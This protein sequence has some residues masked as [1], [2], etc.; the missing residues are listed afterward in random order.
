MRV[1]STILGSLMIFSLL[2]STA[3]FAENL[4][5]SASSAAQNNTAAAA[6]PLL[7]LLVSKGVING[8]EAKSLV[9]TP[10]Q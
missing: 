4:P 1:R 2:I 3:A 7:Q 8:E 9:G 5:A 10:A 6:D